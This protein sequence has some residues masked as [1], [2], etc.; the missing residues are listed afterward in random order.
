MDQCLVNIYKCSHWWWE[1]NSKEIRSE[2]K[3]LAD[4][5]FFI[6]ENTDFSSIQASPTNVMNDQWQSIY[7]L[8]GVGLWQGYSREGRKYKLLPCYKYTTTYV[9]RSTPSVP[10]PMLTLLTQ[11]GF[12]G[13][14]VPIR[15]AVPYR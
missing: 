13:C 2:L 6:L 4:W 10:D 7:L 3:C 12:Y 15:S 8:N 5:D 14:S 9:S 11:A 1:R